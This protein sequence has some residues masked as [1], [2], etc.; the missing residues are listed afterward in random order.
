MKM[1]KLNKK[2]GF[3]L[4]LLISPVIIAVIYLLFIENLLKQPRL[5]LTADL[6]IE[7]P[8]DWSLFKRP[9]PNHAVLKNKLKNDQTCYIDI[10][11]VKPDRDYTFERWLGTSIQ[12]DI[13]LKSGKQTTLNGMAAIIGSYNFIDDYFR[14]TVNNQRIILKING[15]FV[16]LHL[17]YK[18]NETCRQTYQSLVDSVVFK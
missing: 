8:Q 12:N 13:F 4:L 14:E 17:T 9:L 7:V 15:T 11:A 2:K 18:S 6:T 10:F 3:F 5:N 1:R 16:D